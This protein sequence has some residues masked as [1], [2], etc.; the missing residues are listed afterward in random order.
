MQPL[1]NQHRGGKV[2]PG[3]GILPDAVVEHAQVPQALGIQRVIL[4]EHL[5]PQRE[6][7]QQ[8]RLGL[9]WLAALLIE[10]AERMDVGHDRGMLGSQNRAANFQGLAIVPLGLVRLQTLRVEI[11]QVVEDVGRVLVA[12]TD[13]LFGL[14]KQLQVLPFG[15][16]ELALLHHR[17]GQVSRVQ[18]IGRRIV[19]QVA[20]GRRHGLGQSRLGLGK[21]AGFQIQHS[22]VIQHGGAL[23]GLLA[24]RLG[25]N[26]QSLAIQRLRSRVV[27]PQPMHDSQ[28]GKDFARAG[29]LRPI[30]LLKPADGLL[31]QRLRLGIPTPL[32]LQV[33]QLFERFGVLQRVFQ[34]AGSADGQG[35]FQVAPRPAALA[36]GFAAVG[37]LDQ[38]QRHLRMLRTERLF[39]DGENLREQRVVF[40]VLAQLAVGMDLHLQPAGDQ[41]IVGPQGPFPALDERQVVP[42]HFLVPIGELIE[43]HRLVVGQQ[44]R[45]LAGRQRGQLVERLPKHAGIGGSPILGA[46]RP[47]GSGLPGLGSCASGGE[48]IFVQG[49]ERD[50]LVRA[51]QVGVG[52]AQ[53]LAF[54]RQ[55]G[56]GLVQR[57]P[58]VAGVIRFVRPLDRRIALV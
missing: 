3:F 21:F 23:G 6:R 16:V 35:L 36:G 42:R 50:P 49:Q 27:A 43:H 12:A 5:L 25:E 19:G 48:R 58:P 31:Q 22:Q 1:V 28:G 24:V 30:K 54:E 44:L 56:A 53:G 32:A 13:P 33:A 45:Q 20:A 51:H 9:G 40:V 55:G 34:L 18:G 29:I 8:Q 17:G 41:R 11:S 7:F 2:G 14:G 37:Q 47:L 46:V 38:R 39:P 52:L 4:A 10:H 15:L 26:L 57:L